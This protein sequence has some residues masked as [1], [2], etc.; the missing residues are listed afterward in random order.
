MEEKL[1]NN[2][3]NY[4]ALAQAV[5][6]ERAENPDAAH[7]SD[8]EILSSILA[9]HAQETVP[10]GT[11]PHA[12]TATSASPSDDSLPSYAKEIPDDVKAQVEHLVAATLK[13]GIAAGIAQARSL[14]DPFVMDVFHDALLE[15]LIVHLKEKKLL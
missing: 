8:K 6:K 15:K 10:I 14:K 11:A 1:L 13:D 12:T 2:S 4:E 5:Q 9:R 3:I 7:K